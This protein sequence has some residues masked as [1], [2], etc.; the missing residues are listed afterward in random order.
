MPLEPKTAPLDLPSSQALPSP[1]G[2]ARLVVCLEALASPQA[3]RS[4]FS[5]QVAR[6][7]AEHR[8]VP[9][10]GSARVEVRE[11]RRALFE[12][13]PELAAADQPDL[14]CYAKNMCTI[15]A[16]LKYRA[17]MLR[18]A[19]ELGNA[20]AEHISSEFKNIRELGYPSTKVARSGHR[21]TYPELK[22]LL[23]RAEELFVPTPGKRSNARM[24]A[25]VVMTGE[26]PSL[27]ALHALHGGLRGEAQMIFGARPDTATLAGT[28]VSLVVSGSRKSIQECFDI[29]TKALE[30]GAKIAADHR[31]F[32]PVVRTMAGFVMSGRFNSSMQ[33]A[34]R[35]Y[36]GLYREALKLFARSADTADLIRT[37]VALRLKGVYKTT[38]EAHAA[39]KTA[40][41]DMA[42]E[43]AADESLG[44]VSRSLTIYVY[45]KLYK[46]AAEIVAMYRKTLARAHELFDKDDFG[47]SLA[48]T[49]TDW[50]I[51]KRFKSVDAVWKKHQALLAEAVPGG[52]ADQDTANLGRALV[53]AVLK[54]EYES[55]G[56]ARAIFPAI[57]SSCE[58]VFGANPDTKDVA[59]TAAILVFNG[60]YSDAPSALRSYLQH[61]SDVRAEFLAR[62]LQGELR[63]RPEVMRRFQ[64]G[65]PATKPG[66]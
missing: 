47:R 57:R 54:G 53:F 41:A 11:L 58:E 7:L 37:T 61:L 44:K 9:P 3:Q 50:V 25:V 65:P 12:Q 18:E 51:H 56:A 64:S 32:A 5:E 8:P 10:S 2:D 42:V 40:Q 27:E 19:P 59:R 34:Y 16:L 45:S 13:H 36:R 55:I 66:A 46:D 23:T 31:F 30:D 14:A 29:Y 15:L 20:I 48:R 6:D 33:D 38:E 22:Q 62:G 17:S 39:F 63:L 60:T 49:V 28:A 4:M 52:T 21:W 35:A 1:V 43:V 24:M 26:Y